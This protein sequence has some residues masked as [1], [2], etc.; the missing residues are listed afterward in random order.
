MPLL[1]FAQMVI[2]QG[3]AGRPVAATGPGLIGAL[4][5]LLVFLAAGIWVIV[6]VARHPDDPGG[7]GDGGWGGGGGRYPPPHSPRTGPE[8]DWWPEFERQFAEHV[9]RQPTETARRPSRGPILT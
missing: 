8:P 6:Y 5:S 2:G 7:D 4:I 9:R 3:V 1:T